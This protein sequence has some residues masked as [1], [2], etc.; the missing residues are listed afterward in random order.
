MKRNIKP[1]KS[2]HALESFNNM[3]VKNNTN[4]AV[5]NVISAY[6]KLQQEKLPVPFSVEKLQIKRERK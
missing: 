6:I 5:E 4:K 3:L 2:L 1:H